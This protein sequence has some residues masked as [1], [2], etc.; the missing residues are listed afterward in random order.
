MKDIKITDATYFPRPQAMYKELPINKV[1]GAEAGEYMKAWTF[2]GLI[3]LASVG[4]YDDGKEWLHVSVSRRSRLPT[5][6][7]LTRVKRDFIGDDKKAVLVPRKKK[8]M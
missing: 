1:M 3:I 2:S 8:S 6:E 5:Y 7:E 4:K